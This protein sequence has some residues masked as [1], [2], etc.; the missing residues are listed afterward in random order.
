MQ[1]QSFDIPNE[2]CVEVNLFW[3]IQILHTAL[4]EDG[5][6]RLYYAQLPDNKETIVKFFCVTTGQDLPPTFPGKY[7]ATAIPGNRIGLHNDDDVD[8]AIHLFCEVPTQT[9]GRPAI[10]NRPAAGG[11][12]GPN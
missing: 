6:L 1:I 4:K 12:H 8:N 7:L 10:V 9:A 3:P 2:E 5:N 11:E